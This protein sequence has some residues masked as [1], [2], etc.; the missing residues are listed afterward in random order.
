VPQWVSDRT[1]EEQL[2]GLIKGNTLPSMLDNGPPFQ[3]DG[4]FGGCAGIGELKF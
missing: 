3:I 2:E 1:A 4:N